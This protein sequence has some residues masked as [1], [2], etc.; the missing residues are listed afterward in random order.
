MLTEGRISVNGKIEHR[1]KRELIKGN[2]REFYRR[3]GKADAKTTEKILTAVT[4]N[5]TWN[6]ANEVWINALLSNPKTHIIN[7]TSNLVNTFVNLTFSGLNFIGFFF[8][9]LFHKR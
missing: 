7:M 6:M 2:R 3:I 4:K 8:S 9:N 1:A 5:K